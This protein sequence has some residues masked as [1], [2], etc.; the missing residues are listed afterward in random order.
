MNES[1]LLISF[2]NQK[3]LGIRY[4]EKSLKR[5]GY[6]V[7]LV[8]FKGF[9]SKKPNGATPKELDLLKAV[10]DKLSPDLI[11]LS[12]MT[13]LY[14]ETV[15]SVN[16]MIKENYQIPI[17]WGGVYASL[18]PE[19]C[20][21][22]ANF[23]IRGEGE[24]AIIDL[25]NALFNNEPYKSVANLVYRDDTA[26][27]MNDLRPLCQ[28]LDE[29][30]YPEIG[31]D[32]KFFINND[33]ISYGDPQLKELNYEL[34][35]SRG[36]PFVCSYCCSVNLHRMYKGK[37]N[38]V[39]FRSVASVM[40][41]L[42][43]AKNKL[44]RLKVIHFWDE[45]FSDDPSWIDEF[46]FRYKKEINLP[47]EIWGHPLKVNK[48]LIQKLVSAGLY[49]VVMGVQSGSPRVRKKIF[50]RVEKQTDI[51]KASKIL[52]DCKVP[53]VIY[54]FMLQ[55]PFETEEDIKQTYELCLELQAPFELALHG[56]N[57][58]PGTDIV[59]MAIEMNIV[60]KEELERIMY[61]SMQDQYS[62][63]WGYK[64]HNIMS[65]FWY[66]L[67]F[68]S[69]FAFAKPL[70]KYFAARSKSQAHIKSAIKLSKLLKP[71]KK[72][73]YFYKKSGIVFRAISR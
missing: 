59:D 41:E 28:D 40:E 2:H 6:S 10:I 54:D 26:I 7:N 57:F 55:H 69:Q 68:M 38:Y 72:I 20:L 43:E 37:G 61:S 12:V 46:V 73:N 5:A 66:S 22:Y 4:L 16:E 23:V 71:V 27:N 50:H 18:F 14:L 65:D 9:N 29:F 56:L 47:F 13:S 48:E 11:G 45:I 8:F 24:K 64:Y 34:T 33:I 39:R 17:V 53:Q 15:Y 30:G 25:A 36:C 35:A 3:A 21:G 62:L 58:L 44:S 42:I 1:I 63:Y 51:I 19:K 52:S 67:I 49:K 60:D 31:G 70:T 32:N